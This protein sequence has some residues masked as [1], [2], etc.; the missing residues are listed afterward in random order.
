MLPAITP[1]WSIRRSTNTINAATPDRNEPW[2]GINNSLAWDKDR[3]FV[4]NRSLVNGYWNSM[5]YTRQYLL[6]PSIPFKLCMKMKSFYIQSWGRKSIYSI[7][8]GLNFHDCKK[9]LKI[10]D[11]RKRLKQK[12]VM[13][14]SNPV[15]KPFYWP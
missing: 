12:L 1:D 8:R 2:T 5:L 10:K 4:I 14:I 13:W 15:A 3:Q 7:F 9:Q 6:F 11:P